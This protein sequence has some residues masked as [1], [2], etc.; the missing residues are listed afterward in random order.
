MADDTSK[1]NAQDSGRVNVNERHELAYWTKKWGVTEQEL[2]DAVARAG[3]LAKDVA[4]Q[5]GK[6]E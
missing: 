4:R 6:P 5:L 1:R 3:P 2:R